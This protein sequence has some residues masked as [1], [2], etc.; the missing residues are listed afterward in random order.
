[1]VASSVVYEV[2]GSF[3]LKLYLKRKL[4]PRRCID[5]TPY[6]CKGML[7]LVSNLEGGCPATREFKSFFSS[8]KAYLSFLS[9]VS[10]SSSSN[11]DVE[12]QGKTK[13]LFESCALLNAIKGR[14]SSSSMSS[15]QTS[16]MSMGKILIEQKRSGSRFM[17]F[18][19][20]RQLIVAMVQWTRVVATFVATASEQMGKSIDVSSYGLDVDVNQAVKSTSDSSS[21]SSEDESSPTPKNSGSSPTPTDSG[22][23]PTPTDSGSSPTPTDSGSSPTPKN[24][25][26]SPKPTNSGSSPVDQSDSSSKTKSTGSKSKESSGSE[27]ST[28]S[29]GAAYTDTTGTNSASTPSG[30]PTTTSS[31]PSTTTGDSSSTTSGSSKQ[32]SG[33][34]SSSSPTPSSSTP[35]PSTSTPTP[36]SSTPTPS[37]STPTPSSTTPTTSSSGT[38]SETKGSGSASSEKSESQSSSAST[39]VKQVET[40]TSS[41]VMSFIK[42]LEKKYTGNAE[43]KVFFDKLKTSM[44]ASS[45]ISATN[46]QDLISV[47]K[48]AAGRLSEAMMFVRSRFSK[49]EETKSSMESCQEQVMKSVKDLQELNSEIASAK[50]VTSTQKTELKQTIT[51]WEQVTT[52]FVETAASSSSSSSSSQQSSSSQKKTSASSQES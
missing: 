11:V 51:K 27:T 2:Q 12:L 41:E 20:R 46:G 31:G 17:S 18:R 37:T 48:S 15:F 16:M 1:M 6:A 7:M 50:T 10:V 30:S 42:N 39:S 49:S 25:G 9:S 14:R 24:S 5:F 23:S 38:E 28:K 4:F 40:E 19:Q 32:T 34:T 44:D 8:F 13:S 26:S 35:T 47:M 33:K 36:S 21:S 43:L 22:S 45:K 3:L 29:S 52:K